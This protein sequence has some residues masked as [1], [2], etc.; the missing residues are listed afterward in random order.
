MSQPLRVVI[1]DDHPLFREG[2]VHILKSDPGIEVVGEGES[3]EDALC[4]LRQYQPDILLLDLDMPG[5]G[6]AVV[7]RAAEVAPATKVV[8][9]TASSDEEH[10][11]A[12]FRAGVRGYILKG[13]SSR[14]LVAILRSIHAGK[15]YVPPSLGALLISGLASPAPRPAAPTPLVD[16]TPRE[17]QILLQIAAG[18]SNK[19]IGTAF[20]LTEKTVK[21]YVS[22]ILLKLQVRN[23]VEAAL[24]V[25]KLQ[26]AGQL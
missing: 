2:V 13:V 4:A 19:E 21:Y 1:I 11:I 24:L 7:A 18:L 6:L 10:A 22:N 16:L 14:E 8:V 26:A 17:Q 25:Q 12:A 23:R 3:A 20:N 5:G 15:G 9:L